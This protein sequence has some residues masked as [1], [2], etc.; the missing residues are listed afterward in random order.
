[1]YLLTANS[2]NKEYKGEQQLEGKTGVGRRRDEV[3]A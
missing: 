2:Y 3:S 1:M